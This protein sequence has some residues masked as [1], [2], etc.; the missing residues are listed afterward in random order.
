VKITQNGVLRNIGTEWNGKEYTGIKMEYAEG[1][2]NDSGIRWDM[3]EQ[4]GMTL[5]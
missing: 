2:R 3:L 5:E 1:R 4:G